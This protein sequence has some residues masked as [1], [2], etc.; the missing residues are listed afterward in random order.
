[1][2]AQRGSVAKDFADEEDNTSPSYS[3]DSE[4]HPRADSPPRTYARRSSRYTFPPPGALIRPRPPSEES[5]PT[6]YST[7]SAVHSRGG[8]PDSTRS[9]ARA[10]SPLTQAPVPTS[11]QPPAVQNALP[12]SAASSSSVAP[13]HNMPVE[14][15]DNLSFHTQ[16]LDGREHSKFN[17]ATAMAG[18]GGA[19]RRQRPQRF[20]AA[21]G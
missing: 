8:T 9:H 7:D 20:C 6:S 13:A 10:T 12:Q 3:T 2:Q 19:G 4:V 11:R 5:R 15:P 18:E 1:M 17:S 14:D 16:S 21:C